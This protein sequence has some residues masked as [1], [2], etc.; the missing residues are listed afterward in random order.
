MVKTGYLIDCLKPGSWFE[1]SDTAC[2]S[3]MDET[4]IQASYVTMRLPSPGEAP[5]SAEP[6]Q[7]ALDDPVPG[8]NAKSHQLK[9]FSGLT[10]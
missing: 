4:I 2:H 10:P 6:C 8:Q 1:F 5:A 3:L 9:T 7:S